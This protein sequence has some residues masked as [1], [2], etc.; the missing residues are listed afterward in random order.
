M[1][2]RLK[3]RPEAQPQR[4]GDLDAQAKQADMFA[5][6]VIRVWDDVKQKV[7]DDKDT[8]LDPVLDLMGL[9]G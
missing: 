5:Q 7:E 6:S 4:G 2:A 9:G 3:K 1:R 8:V